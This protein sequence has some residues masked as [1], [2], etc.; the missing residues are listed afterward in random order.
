MRNN[1]KRLY[2]INLFVLIELQLHQNFVMN[3]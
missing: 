1:G 3:L 2:R